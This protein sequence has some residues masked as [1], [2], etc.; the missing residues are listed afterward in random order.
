M[1]SSC[2]LYLKW[3]IL[4]FVS[5]ADRYVLVG[6]ARDSWGQSE[7]G[8]TALL[9]EL[10]AIFGQL[11]KEGEVIALARRQNPG[12]RDAGVEMLHQLCQL[13]QLRQLLPSRKLTEV[14]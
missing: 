14:T 10:T 2:V 13:Y 11:L 7:L 8:S 1:R 12:S 3:S 5:S 6:S 9:L 4:I